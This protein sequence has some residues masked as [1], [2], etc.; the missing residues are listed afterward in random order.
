LEGHDQ[1]GFIRLF[2]ELFLLGLVVLL[3]RVLFRG[4]FRARSERILVALAPAASF[5]DRLFVN[6]NQALVSVSVWIIKYLFNVKLEDPKRPFS[7]IDLEHYFQ[8]TKESEAE[9]VELNKELF[10]N[11][12]SLPGVKVR[13]CLVPRREIVGVDLKASLEDVV[14]KM[15]ETK[16]SRLIVYDGSVDNIVG[17]VHQLDLFKNPQNLQ[18][19]LLPITAVPETMTVSDLIDKL[20]QEGRSIA[21]VVDEFGGTAGIV[22]ME[23]LLE[24]IFGEIR[25]EYDTE[26]FVDKQLATDEYIFSG[27]LELDFLKEKYGL[28]FDGAPTETVSGYI[29]SHHDEM[30]AQGSTIFI[31]KYQFDILNMSATRI[32]LVKVKLL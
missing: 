10:E 18:A 9:N 11:A 26:E 22:T 24:E 6:L 14:S 8:Q 12:L 2:I 28:V 3:V 16:L 17:Y 30:P 13:S 27:R 15:I 7:R 20:T 1:T 32:D 23:D 4:V 5:F 31:G 21:W 29:I 25:D 19:V